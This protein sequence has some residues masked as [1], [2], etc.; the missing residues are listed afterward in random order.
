M[1]IFPTVIDCSRDI[2]TSCS[3]ESITGQNPLMAFTAVH[4][5]PT[6]NTAIYVPFA[7]GYPIA[8]AMIFWE[9]GTVSG[10]IDVGIYSADG[11]KLVS[12]GSTALSGATSI[13][14]VDIIDTLLQR[15]LYYMAMAIDN[16]T[17]TVRTSNTLPIQN[18][19]CGVLS[20]ATAF[21]L[22]ATSTPVGTTVNFIPYLAL[23]TK[24]TI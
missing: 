22:P 5:W 13:Q 18:R 8:I 9:N 14:S 6:A 20:Q 23:T 15:G 21:A 24:A 2:I 19:V 7:V 3:L 11:T 1:S 17:A 16:T 10:N 4:A 12:S